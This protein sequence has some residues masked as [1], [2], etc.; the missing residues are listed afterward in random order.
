MNIYKTNPIG[1]YEKA[2]LNNF[3]WEDKI[4]IAK[5][6]GYDFIEISIDESEERLSRLKW[7]KEEKVKF[8]QLLIDKEFDIPSMCLSGHRL[9]PFG[10]KDPNKV[11]RAYEIIDDAID[12]A[13]NVGVRNIQLAGYDVYY[14]DSNED[15]LKRFYEG[16][17][18]CAS[19]GRR[20][21][22]MLSIE[23]MDTPFLGTIENCMKYINKINSPYLKVYPDIGNLTRFSEKPLY[24][25]EKY[26][27]HIVAI[28]L[29]DTRE[30]EFKCVDFGKGDVNFEKLFI[31][32]KELNYS[33]PFL[34]EM[35]A[36]NEILE[37]K[38]EVIIRLNKWLNY[39]KDKMK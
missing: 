18:Y 24:E 2:I 35:W 11:K 17:N 31:K 14:E 9:Y 30:G 26:I 28:H 22:I 29:K 23:I 3:S 5:K 10:S 37:S 8:K 36:N 27:E 33:G 15:T 4:D 19:I 21:N 1:L 16:L 7:S 12:F 20:H 32:L 6:A 13:V 39:I 38:E 25:I 34:M